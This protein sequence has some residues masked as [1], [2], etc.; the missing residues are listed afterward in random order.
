MRDTTSELFEL[1]VHGGT[2]E[3]HFHQRRPHADGMPWGRLARDLPNLLTDDELAA[4]Q[5]GWMDLALQEYGAAASQSD[6]LRLLVRARAPIDL[7]AMLAE[8]PLDELAHTDLC[9]RMGAELGGVPP[10]SYRTEKVFPEPV[11]GRG[12]LLAQAARA[13]AW[14]FCVGETLS[15]G[16]LAFHVKHARHPL[17]AAVWGRLAKDEAA[18]ARFG[19]LFMDWVRPTLTPTERREVT[20][21]IE[22]AIAHVDELDAKVESLP[23]AAFVEFGV[24][25]ACG[26]KAYLAETRAILD[27]RVV[28]RL[29]AFSSD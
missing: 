24:F 11:P 7:T 27:R 21:T 4:A 22:R 20:R 25:G 2:S 28:A 3:R 13:V 29:R 6:V 16:L 17:L 18:H 26:R 23:D 9:A 10:L 12:S 5:R 19:W 14:E 1:D 15:Q 8:F